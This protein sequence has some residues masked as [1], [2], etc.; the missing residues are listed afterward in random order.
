MNFSPISNC[1]RSKLAIFLSSNIKLL[2]KFIVAVKVGS[3]MSTTSALRKRFRFD[4]A[5]LT[6]F[7]TQQDSHKERCTGE[8]E[9]MVRYLQQGITQVR[10]FNLV[11]SWVIPD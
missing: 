5:A 10:R 11:I 9:K 1:R 8:L 6:Y 3:H 4:Y 2:Y 7:A